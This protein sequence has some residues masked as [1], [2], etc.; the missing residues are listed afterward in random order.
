MLVASIFCN[1]VKMCPGLDCVKII[2]SVIR[3]PSFIRVLL[4][5]VNSVGLF[6]IT[7]QISPLSDYLSG[8][9]T[10]GCHSD[11][12]IGRVLTIKVKSY[13]RAPAR[14]H[15]YSVGKNTIRKLVFTGNVLFNI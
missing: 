10:L 5:V 9:C 11:S 15:F 6:Q 14:A 4:L 12:L 2:K 8:L 13:V 3:L 1:G 7:E